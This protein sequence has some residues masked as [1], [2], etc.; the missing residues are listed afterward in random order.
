MSRSDLLMGQTGDRSPTEEA[1]SIVAMPTEPTDK[2]P[3]VVSFE[4]PPAESAPAPCHSP[5][6]EAYERRKTEKK[7]ERR[8]R[9]ES[10]NRRAK[11]LVKPPP[12]S[13]PYSMQQA[14]GSELDTNR[15]RRR[16]R[17]DGSTTPNNPIQPSRKARSRSGSFVSL[18]R[19][20]FEFRRLSV[21]H[22]QDFNFIGGIK[23]EMQQTAA[24]QQF[25]YTQAVEDESNVHPALRSA[26]QSNRWSEPLKS[27]PPPLRLGVDGEDLRRYPPITRGKAHQKTMSLVSPTAP[28]VPDLSTIDKW[29]AKVGLKTGFS[30]PGSRMSLDNEAHLGEAGA[31]AALVSSIIGPRDMS[32]REQ[33]RL[34]SASPTKC[35]H[36]VLP[37]GPSP[38]EKML[39]I[40]PKLDNSN[41]VSVS[42][43]STGT[44]YQTAPSLSPPEPP[45]RSP[46]R[47]SALSMDG[48][49]SPILPSPKNSGSAPP[50]PTQDT[51][52]QRS[53]RL[54]GE[55]PRPKNMTRGHAI[56]VSASISQQ[57]IYVPPTGFQIPGS[58]SEDSGSDDFLSTSIVS[59]PATSRP[60]SEKGM[61]LEAPKHERSK[62]DGKSKSQLAIPDSTYPLHS[63]ANSEDE[64]DPIQTAA[65]KVLAVFN[66]IPVKTP[67]LRRRSNSQSTLATHA[68]LPAPLHERPLQ[69]RPGNTAG[70]SSQRPPSPATYLEE[71]RKQPP[72]AR[73]H[74]TRKKHLGPPA[75]F[76][77]PESD[78]DATAAERLP[79]SVPDIVGRSLRHKSTPLLSMTDREPIA[80]VF[81]EC[82]SCKYYHDMPSNLYEAMAN[83][84]GMLNSADKCGFAGALSMT[85]K[86]AWCRHEMSTR[87]CAGLA[88]T[89]Y[90]K[91]RL[92]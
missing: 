21:D 42:S 31:A 65:E 11:K 72:A 3:K 52:P 87:C 28:A 79:P 47:H 82:C 81:V 20:P 61:P 69:L 25:L 12:V 62:P 84:E 9:E 73:Q 48:S 70:L 75:S 46:K 78:S 33:T 54:C 86:C 89:L 60:Q 67:G 10:K 58:L 88:A 16:D 66:D 90:I 55:G 39:G 41:N 2:Y 49:I 26:K 32:S 13:S 44:T 37:A 4:F 92:H 34:A 27:P 17:A 76:V 36:I 24:T 51:P 56:G 59:T 38:H 19:A 50:S 57:A 30:R 22:G 63:T 43:C 80:K 77:L 45:R 7:T 6:W 8:E 1:S 64:A 91:E 85:V 83:P 40:Q 5:S 18:L 23:L 35:T 74:R 14:S 71:A 29:R 53:F 68:T 15:G